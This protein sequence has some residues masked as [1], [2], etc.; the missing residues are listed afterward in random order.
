MLI[1]LCSLSAI[2]TTHSI[3]QCSKM[4]LLIFTALGS[5]VPMGTHTLTS[6]VD[7]AKPYTLV[8]Y[9]EPVKD[10]DR[11]QLRGMQQVPFPFPCLQQ[12]VNSIHRNP[13]GRKWLSLILFL[14]ELI[15]H[16]TD[17]LVHRIV[18]EYGCCRPGLL[19]AIIMDFQ[20]SPKHPV[21]GSK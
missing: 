9:S 13:I 19:S 8:R 1:L 16:G 15:Q 11:F 2:H 5:N 6:P 17:A 7:Q 10:L 21:P 12:L 18:S 20:A 3:L 4:R 14:M